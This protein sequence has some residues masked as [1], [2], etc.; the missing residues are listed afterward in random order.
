MVVVWVF[1][2]IAALAVEAA[3]SAAFFAFFL[4]I[5]FAAGAVADTFG[6]PVWLQ[7][8]LIAGVAGAGMVLLRPMLVSRF[9]ATAPE[10]L[11]G[12]DLVGQRALT[13]D[14]VGDEHHPGHALLAGERWLAVSATSTTLPPD[15]PVLVAGVRGTTLLVLPAP[16]VAARPS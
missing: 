3:I 14:E 15:V 6:L 9:N 2:A 11:G 4:A 1:L 8:V 16:G 10:L 13:V 5:G 12:H 7:L